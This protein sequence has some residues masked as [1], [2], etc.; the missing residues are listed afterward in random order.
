MTKKLYSPEDLARWE[1]STPRMFAEYR[2]ALSEPPSG[3][4]GGGYYGLADLHVQEAHISIA[5]DRYHR[6]LGHLVAGVESMCVLY[7]KYAAGAKFHPNY[8]AAMNLFFLLHAHTT[9]QVPLIERF[10]AAYALSF[11]GAPKADSMVESLYIGS[12]M[13]ALSLKQVDEAARL[14]SDPP[15]LGRRL[16]K[17]DVIAYYEGRSE[18]PPSLEKVYPGY[19]ACLAAIVRRD[20]A[21]F[22]TAMLA[23]DEKWYKY[24]KH[25]WKGLPDCVSFLYGAGLVCLAEWAWGHEV[26]VRTP[27]LPDRLLQGNCLPPR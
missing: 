9:R 5:R 1:A 3:H 11:G 24:A 17:G 23:A 16:T 8:V 19:Y 12:L 20:E 2:E 18:H 15:V 13:L 4:D 22:Q 10:S 25:N 6:A 21:G 7:E 27:N 14:L 26:N